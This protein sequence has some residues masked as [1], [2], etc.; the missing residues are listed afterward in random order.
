MIERRDETVNHILTVSIVT[1][2]RLFKTQTHISRR[3]TRPI[4]KGDVPARDEVPRCLGVLS[5]VASPVRYFGVHHGGRAGGRAVEEG[6]PSW[7]FFP[8]LSFSSSSSSSSLYQCRTSVVQSL[9]SLK[10]S[11][12]IPREHEKKKK[13]E[14]SGFPSLC[15]G[16]EKG[17]QGSRGTDSYREREKAHPHKRPSDAERVESECA[18]PPPFYFSRELSKVRQAYLPTLF[19][20]SMAGCQKALSFLASY[21]NN[22]S[23]IDFRHCNSCGAQ[24]MQLVPRLPCIQPIAGSK[25]QPTYLRLFSCLNWVNM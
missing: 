24:D 14:R 10:E 19:I 12:R 8:L 4:S 1:S 13:S 15:T 11:E 18:S 9:S 17:N 3:A 20:R 22:P 6:F 5:P 25:Y 23:S 2:I 16:R 7:S 21:V